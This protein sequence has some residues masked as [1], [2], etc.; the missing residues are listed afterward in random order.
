MSSRFPNSVR[1]ATREGSGLAQSA[2]YCSETLHFG[3]TRVIVTVVTLPTMP[4]SAG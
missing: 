2:R 3:S 4:A 1:L